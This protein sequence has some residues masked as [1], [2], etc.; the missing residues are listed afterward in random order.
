MNKEKQIHLQSIIARNPEIIHNDI[1]G[2]VVIMS[3][4]QNKFYGI[5]KIGTCIWKLLD[6]PKNVENIIDE[7]LKQ[8]NVTREVCETDILS[9]LNKMAH[10]NMLIITECKND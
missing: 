10:Q 1:D 6:T 7:M 3:I 2:E 4:E 8:Y 5:D 9:F